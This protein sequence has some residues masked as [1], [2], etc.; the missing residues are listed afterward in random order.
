MPLL[1]IVTINR[2]NGFGL[3]RTL[4]SVAGQ[5][6]L[7]RIHMI[8]VDGGS[9][10][11][12]PDVI[13][14][15]TELLGATV[16]A[17]TDRGIYDAMN[18]GLALAL[19]RFTLFLNSGDHLIDTKVVEDFAT[20]VE[21]RGNSPSVVMG[22]IQ[23]GSQTRHAPDKPYSFSR[24]LLG[25]S[26]HRHP[27]S[28]VP[29]DLAR[30]LGGY[31]EDYEFSGDYDFMLRAAFAVGI[32]E[33]PRVCTVFDDVGVSSRNEDRIPA[34]LA[35]IRRE[36]LQPTGWMGTVLSAYDRV[37]EHR[38]RRARRRKAETSRA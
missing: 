30:A 1:S 24:H 26:M 20:H 36:R 13:A 18:K 32:D 19:G 6:A 27:A 35:R 33:W 29:T 15:Y 25:L 4:R 5:T 31:S 10:D 9:S 3:E 14:E 17:E 28:F 2:N 34:L 38:H 37:F 11:G 12:S 7:D 21:H 8:I 22:Q 23:R 16:I